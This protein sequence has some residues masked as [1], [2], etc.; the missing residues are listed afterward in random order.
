MGPCDQGLGREWIRCKAA[1]LA[2]DVTVSYFGLISCL[3]AQRNSE[4]G[5]RIALWELVIHKSLILCFSRGVIIAVAGCLCKACSFGLRVSASPYQPLPNFAS[6]QV[7]GDTECIAA[8]V[9][10]W[11]KN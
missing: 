3:V 7:P 4:F 1:Q 6:A 5:V 9:I 2:I 11:S 8:Y 10:V